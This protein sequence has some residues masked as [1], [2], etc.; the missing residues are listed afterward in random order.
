MQQSSLGPHSATLQ[1]THARM[2]ADK[3]EAEEAIITRTQQHMET[4]KNTTCSKDNNTCSRSAEERKVQ[5][6]KHSDRKIHT[7]SHA[8]A[9]AFGQ[10]PK[11]SNLD[12]KHTKTDAHAHQLTRHHADHSNTEA[13]EKAS[14]RQ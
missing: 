9:A 3:A 7:S 4:Q 1:Q 6:R 2:T 5:H 11:C 14:P 10:L 12:R 8:D 13:H